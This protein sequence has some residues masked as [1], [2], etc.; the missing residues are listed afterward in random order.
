MAQISIQLR[1]MSEDD[2]FSTDPSFASRIEDLERDP[3]G[4]WRPTP[5]LIEIAD[6]WGLGEIVGIRWFNPRGSQR[7]LVYEQVTD[8]NEITLRWVDMTTGGSDTH[9]DIAV[10]RRRP[11][12]S[13]PAHFLQIGRWLLYFNG[14]EHPIRWDGRT[15]VPV[16][17]AGPA[18]APRVVGYTEGFQHFDVAGAALDGTGFLHDEQR[19][20][21]EF[22]NNVRWTYAY[23]ITVVNDRG[24]ESPMSAIVYAHGAST[25]ASGRCGVRIK[26]P[27]MPDNVDAIRLW[28]SINLV[29][30][31]VASPTMQLLDT[32]Q[33]G[34]EFDYIDLAP[35]SELGIAFVPESVGPVPLGIN[36]AEF[37]QGRT[38]VAVDDRLHFSVAGFD[39]VFPEGNYL[40]IGAGTGRIVAL[41][42]IPAG[43]AVFK[44]HGVYLVK[45]NEL[46]GFRVETLSETE[47]T[48]APRAIEY[49]SGIGLVFLSEHGPRVLRGILEDDQPTAIGQLR[50]IRRT[51]RRHI[52]GTA[53]HNAFV[54]HRPEVE[55]LW[56]HLPEF[57]QVPPT[58]GL[59]LHYGDG[60]GTWSLRP[61]WPLFSGT[62]HDK[63][64]WFGIDGQA[65]LLSRYSWTGNVAGPPEDP[66]VIV[67][68][69]AETVYVGGGGG[70]SKGAP[71]VGVYETGTFVSPTR[72]L[73]TGIEIAGLVVGV[74][75]SIDVQV[76]YGRRPTF[77]QTSDTTMLPDRWSED[78]RRDVWGEATFDATKRWHDYEPGFIARSVMGRLTNQLQF[79]LSGTEMRPA[80]LRVNL[81][82]P[83]GNPAIM[84]R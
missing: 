51:W 32:F 62:T 50:G 24:Q 49:V 22:G 61:D 12:R 42:S 52:I 74:D 72:I 14:L 8:T 34:A 5:G 69:E 83:D 18:P 13:G 76:R 70:G 40:T 4:V 27:R 38:W 21:G 37:W 35:D 36:A 77:E 78:D 43:L 2:L 57:G 39:E 25:S 33:L 9:R 47:G 82:T 28:R 63:K 6:G 64:V 16:G 53:I 59:V 67:N 48:T 55:E 81:A 44:E 65:Q 26:V 58:L 56:F 7:F 41:R 66:T 30:Q 3:D 60:P 80:G 31:Q 73:P 29:D 68:S 23:G 79:R 10:R 71:I 45:G 20:V 84:E 54:V 75:K 46:S 15:V 19:G 11:A 1:G 17:F